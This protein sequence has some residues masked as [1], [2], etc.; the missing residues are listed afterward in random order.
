VE[1]VQRELPAVTDAELIVASR[2][3]PRA[4]RRLYDRRAD[5]LLAYFYRRVFDPE[6]AADL[7]AE[8]FAV[9]FAKRHRFRDRGVPGVAWLY[10]I[11]RKELS[12]W[13]RHQQVERRALA[14]LGVE[15]PELDAA[16]IAL[17]ETSAE[18]DGYRT[19]LAEAL[20]QI[21][22]SERDAVRLRV[23]SELSY[24]EIAARLRCSE[25]AA[26]TRVCRGLARLSEL[27]EATA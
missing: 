22:T 10:G 23:V 21:S 12:H 5:E 15:V 9:A 14:K 25:A 19:A 27:M 6:V 8:T 1:L 4:F 24:G 13:F 3:D 17:L 18:L 2:D 11:A 7:L 20:E 16:S 26:R